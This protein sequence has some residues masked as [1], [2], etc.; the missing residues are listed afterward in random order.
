[1]CK[2]K[3]LEIRDVMY[4][5]RGHEIYPYHKHCQDFLSEAQTE[6]IRK[7]R[8]REWS[9]DERGLWGEPRST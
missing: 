3:K 1:M 6:E 4:R 2:C 7:K 9:Y 8:T 5:S